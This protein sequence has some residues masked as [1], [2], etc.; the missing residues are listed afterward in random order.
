MKQEKSRA[1]AR[2]PKTRTTHVL[3]NST[4]MVK[5]SGKFE[6]AVWETCSPHTPLSSVKLLIPARC[7]TR[8]TITKSQREPS[9]RRRT[10]DGSSEKTAEHVHEH[11]LRTRTRV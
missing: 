8:G 4:H 5:N 10:V 6:L 9:K 2:A 11:Q 3:R 7:A 1:R